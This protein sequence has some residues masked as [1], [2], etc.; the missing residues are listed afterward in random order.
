M[1]YEKVI[2]KAPCPKG[3]KDFDKKTR[4]DHHDPNLVG[5]GG[6]TTG[7]LEETKK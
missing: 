6:E 3:K 1:S 2:E 5:R 4:T 7:K